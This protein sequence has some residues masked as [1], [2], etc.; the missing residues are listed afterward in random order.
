MQV[1]DREQFDILLE[2]LYGGFN[3]PLSKARSDAYFDGLQKMQLSRFARCVDAALGEDGP[4]RIPS[5]TQVWGIYRKLKLAADPKPVLPPPPDPDHLSYFANRLL[6]T[7]VS[8][9]GGLGSTGRF[10]PA[11]G[12]VDCK[13]S[14]EL[15]ACLKVKA[16][17][18]EFFLELIRE[19]SE[20][21]TPSE[22][23][24]AWTKN[25]REVSVI[26]PKALAAYLKIIA[27]EKQPFPAHMGRQLKAA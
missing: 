19:G 3:M 27:N 14:P 2:K 21:A 8:T 7:H 11:Y 16:E 22:F 26:T 5:V 13:A 9:R 17:L 23:V 1:S 15:T 25:L 6:W 10:I 4:E 20:H 12:M 24:T 18:V